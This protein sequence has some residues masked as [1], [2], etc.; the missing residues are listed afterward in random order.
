MAT[1]LHANYFVSVCQ[2]DNMD[3]PGSLLE[4]VF[5]CVYMC[6]SKNRRVLILVHAVGFIQEG[7]THTLSRGNRKYRQLKGQLVRE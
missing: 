5:L 1:M 7:I 6:T 4:C 3:Q 2:T